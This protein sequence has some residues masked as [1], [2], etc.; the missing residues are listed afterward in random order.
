MQTLLHLS[1][2]THQ[3]TNKK[4]LENQL[5]G[6]DLNES[7][8]EW[9]KSKKVTYDTLKEW[10]FK[11][12][13]VGEYSGHTNKCMMKRAHMQAVFLWPSCSRDQV[14]IPPGLPQVVWAVGERL[15]IC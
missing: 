8:C 13:E 2:T 12:E 5:G 10:V 14:L 6:P 11:P 3:S 1:P 9:T 15:G 4:V 7:A